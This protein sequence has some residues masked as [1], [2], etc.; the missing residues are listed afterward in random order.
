MS[1]KTYT[2]V[3]YSAIP[4]WLLISFARKNP[5]IVEKYYSRIFYPLVFDLHRFFLDMIPFSLGDILYVVLTLFVLKTTFKK[6]S[7]WRAKPLNLILDFGALL[8]MIV[9][10]FHIS[11]G[12][13]Y[14]RLPLSE[15]LQMPI[16][17]SEED[18]VEQLDK[19][20]QQSNQWHNR[21]VSSDT[22][23]VKFPFSKEQLSEKITLYHP[24]YHETLLGTS[25][26]KKSL[27]SL[28]LCYMGYSGYLNPFTLESQV[29]AK[30]PIQSLIT[31]LLHETAHQLGYA[32]EKEANFIAYLSTIKSE[33]PYIQYTGNTFAFKYLFSDLFKLDPEK[34]RNK[35][36]LLNPGILKNFQQVNDFWKKYENPLEII[37][38][39]TYDS[40]LKAN[41]QKSGIKSYNEMV[42]LV[43]N[44]HKNEKRF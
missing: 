17:Y 4:L 35:L 39:K 44:Y 32:A 43:I 23:A 5:D 26:V 33:N 36:K 10:I 22:L 8:I 31:T 16:L 29:N 12:F 19:I 40:Y 3:W 38:D 14:H 2:L 15:Q 13:N 30:M 20:I 34:A 21:L 1:K 24:I 42:G 7:Y 9:W 25:K 41:G 37:F 28:P 11:W 18:L 6:I 27:I